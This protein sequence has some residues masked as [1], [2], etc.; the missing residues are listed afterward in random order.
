MVEKKEDR[1]LVDKNRWWKNLLISCLQSPHWS[2]VGPSSAEDFGRYDNEVFAALGQPM[3]SLTGDSFLLCQ[4]LD[5]NYPDYQFF[6][7]CAP[8]DLNPHTDS[9]SFIDM[10]NSNDDNNDTNPHYSARLS[11]RSNLWEEGANANCVQ[12]E[13]QIIWSSLRAKTI[14]GP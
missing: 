9:D 4:H 5:S 13:W 14:L 1:V 10:T 8:A 7:L 3:A 6:C 12:L 11:V 2:A